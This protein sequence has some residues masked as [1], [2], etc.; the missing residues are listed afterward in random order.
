[1]RNEGD[2]S[3]EMGVPLVSVKMFGKTIRNFHGSK[4]LEVDSKP[5]IVIFSSN[6]KYVIKY[7]NLRMRLSTDLDRLRDVDVKA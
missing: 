3:D 7:V 5:L 6:T 2:P 4:V 1:V